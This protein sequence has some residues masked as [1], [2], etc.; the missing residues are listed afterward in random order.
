MA[1]TGC[2]AKTVRYSTGYVRV[3]SEAD[4][5]EFK[6]VID[7]RLFPG[8]TSSEPAVTVE[9]APFQ[10]VPASRVKRDPREGTIEQGASPAG[11]F[12]SW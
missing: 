3:R 9:Y 11:L 8:K 1:G 2:S 7:G 10:R 4:V 12:M 5:P 6:A